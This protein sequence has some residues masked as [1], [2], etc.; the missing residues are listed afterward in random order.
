VATP[1]APLVATPVVLP[2]ETLPQVVA[3]IVR[4]NRH[5][6]Y[7]DT[8]FA[9]SSIGSGPTMEGMGKHSLPVIVHGRLPWI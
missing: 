6:W 2:V 9:I 4:I 8:D 5:L 7:T 1:T 3:L